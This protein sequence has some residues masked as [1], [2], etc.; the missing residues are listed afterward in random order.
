MVLMFKLL[1]GY[2]KFYFQ[3]AVFCRLHLPEMSFILLLQHFTSLCYP[4]LTPQIAFFSV[5]HL[6]AYIPD[7]YT[8][9]QFYDGTCSVFLDFSWTSILIIACW[10]SIMNIFKSVYSRYLTQYDLLEAVITIQFSCFDELNES[11]CQHLKTANFYPLFTYT[12]NPSV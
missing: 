2:F 9:R 5:V 1:T 11:W 4:L 10:R 6:N 3:R 7:S 12:T 8:S